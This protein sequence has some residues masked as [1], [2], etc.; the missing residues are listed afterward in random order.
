MA[1][2]VLLDVGY[3]AWRVKEA[4]SGE[5]MAEVWGP[6]DRRG[7]AWEAVTA[8]DLLQG[9]ADLLVMRHPRA[10]EAVRSTIHELVG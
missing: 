6:A 5:E 8:T 9:G 7:P 3:E 4:R 10:V 2:P 1:Q